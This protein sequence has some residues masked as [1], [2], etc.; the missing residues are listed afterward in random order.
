MPAV[1]PRLGKPSYMSTALHLGAISPTALSFPL[2]THDVSADAP[3]ENPSTFHHHTLNTSLWPS[4]STGM[5]TTLPSFAARKT[6][7]TGSLLYDRGGRPP[8]TSS[9]HSFAVQL[10]QISCS[11]CWIP[12]ESRPGMLM[13]PGHHPRKKRHR[14]VTSPFLT[15]PDLPISITPT[16]PSVVTL[17]PPP[18]SIYG[19]G[20]WN[21]L[22]HPPEPL[23]LR[24][25][26]PPW[27]SYNS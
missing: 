18:H 25:V 6:S 8:R 11:G 26:A 27:S 3:P 20:Q 22:R 12:P 21:S 2:P 14:G 4:V 7:T 9:Q 1:P 5:L 10:F 24:T 19:G 23:N 16:R 15:R 17:S 13:Q